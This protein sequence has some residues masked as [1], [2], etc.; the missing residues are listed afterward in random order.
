MIAFAKRTTRSPSAVA[1]A[2]VWGEV[3]SPFARDDGHLALAREAGQ[4]AGQALDDALLPAAQRVEIDLRRAEGRCRAT[5][6]PPA[7]SITLA[8]CSSAFEGMQPTLRQTPPSVGRRSTS[9]TFLPRSA[10]RKAAV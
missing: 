6:F 3:N 2:S 4:A 5:T 10:A 9:T 8:A 1:T 7:S